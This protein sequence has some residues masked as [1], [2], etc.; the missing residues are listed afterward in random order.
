M[1]STYDENNQKFA[2]CAVP[3][4]S[5]DVLMS[6]IFLTPWLPADSSVGLDDENRPSYRQIGFSPACGIQT[7]ANSDDLGY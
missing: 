6:R 1:L 2:I 3:R 4:T 7:G 5:A